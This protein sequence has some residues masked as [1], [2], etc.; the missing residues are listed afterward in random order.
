MAGFVAEK[1]EEAVLGSGPRLLRPPGALEE[2]AFLTACTRC[3]ACLLACPQGAI[4]RATGSAR[5]ALGT[6][7]I[8]P[9]AMPCFLCAELPCIAACPEG[10]LLWPGPNGQGAPPAVRMGKAVVNMERCLNGA[11]QEASLQE[12]RTCLERCPYPGEAIRMIEGAAGTPP[13]PEVDA[14]FCTGC[15]LCEF[16]C[17]APDA[18]IVVEPRG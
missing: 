7:Y 1:V 3:D 16:G 5:L 10:A 2:F 13:R 12:C 18:A 6:P 15:G 14:E 9:R 4:L 11:T 17:P 8:A